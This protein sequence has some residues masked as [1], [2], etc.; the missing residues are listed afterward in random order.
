MLIY[1]TGNRYVA[2][3]GRMN[4]PKGR[5]RRRNPADAPGVVGCDGRGGE[6]PRAPTTAAEPLL[7][8]PP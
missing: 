5:R 4:E 2:L 7:G 8:P 3:L 1:R 6:D